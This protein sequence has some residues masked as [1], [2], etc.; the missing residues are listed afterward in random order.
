MSY[1]IVE[2]KKIVWCPGDDRYIQ[3]TKRGSEV[4][5]LSYMQGDDLE[6]FKESFLD[7]D[8]E[9]VDFYNGV[10]HY[11]TGENELDRINQAI[12]G[13]FEFKNRVDERKAL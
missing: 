6:Y 7:N 3:V 2:S 12:W 13:Y 5:G 9:L 1:T 4:I 8:E 11:L 10:R